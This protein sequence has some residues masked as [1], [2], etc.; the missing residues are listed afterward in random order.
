LASLAAAW[1]AGAGLAL[2]GVPV[3]DVVGQ[4]ILGATMLGGASLMHDAAHGMAMPG[5][6]AND[7]IGVVCGA[8]VVVSLTAYRVLHLRHHA[9]LRTPDDPDDPEL[10]AAMWGL[11]LGVFYAAVALFGTAFYIPHIA[12]DGFKLARPAD[13]ARIVA[14]LATP[15]AALAAWAAVWPQGLVTLWAV[16][17][18][19]L[20]VMNQARMLTEHC[21]T[22]PGS[23]VFGARSVRSN[24][25]TRFFLGNANY[26]VEHHLF[27]G[28]PWYRLPELHRL[29]SP[30]LAEVGGAPWPSHRAY[31]LAAAR[32][33]VS[34]PR[35]GWRVVPYAP[36][37]G[38][39]R[40]T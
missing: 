9:H 11:P 4:V 35:P 30:W 15:I 31:L 27:P 3:L 13:R 7:L 17:Y 18:L 40:S 25:V 38:E 22:S 19:W 6:A 12:I 21:L 10:P 24:P 20:A 39:N 8:P 5:R 1:A 29:V 32:A 26:H 37:V 14:E 34:G 23:S 33:V 36:G 28:V 16:P 2:S